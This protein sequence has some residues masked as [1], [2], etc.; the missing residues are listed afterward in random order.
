M[1]INYCNEAIQ[2]MFNRRIFESEIARLVEEGIPVDGIVFEKCTECLSL[3][4]GETGIFR[5]TDEFCFL[6]KKSNDD[7]QLLD[8]MDK[9]HM[10]F[11]PR[12]IGRNSKAAAK[13]PAMRTDTF[14]VKHFAGDAMY[15]INGFI[16]ANGDKLEND[17][18]DVVRSCESDLVRQFFESADKTAAVKLPADATSV[19]KRRHSVKKITI[20][21][22]FRANLKALIT[23]LES[24]NT[25]FLRCIKPNQLKRPD[26]FDAPLVHSQ[27]RYSGVI[28]VVAIR[29]CSFPL[30]QSWSDIHD[31]LMSLKLYKGISEISLSGE[32]SWS[33]SQREEAAKTL[34]KLVFP[35]ESGDYYSG[36]SIVYMK[37]NIYEKISSFLSTKSVICIQQRWRGVVTR[38]RILKVRLAIITLQRLW[39]KRKDR[40][41]R[42]F[43]II[44]C[45]AFFRMCNAKTALVT[46]RRM[47][48]V[49]YLLKRWRTRAR[50]RKRR[51]TTL[52]RLFLLRPSWRLP[53]SRMP[54][55]HKK[56]TTWFRAKLIRLDYLKLRA[57]VT[58]ISAWYRGRTAYRFYRVEIL[59]LRVILRQR[60]ERHGVLKL[61]KYVTLFL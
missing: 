55:A 20:S 30:R 52:I 7:M 50:I 33:I 9:T 60:R 39:W 10:T 2:A 16:N 28:G 53:I 44:I 45:Q 11:N 56:L 47:R 24:T 17:L 42:L 59:Q 4:E 57:A 61:V 19:K 40:A 5:L 32:H 23:E 27:L 13:F 21:A 25:Q 37:Q 48:E 58:R 38:Q 34:F 43:C 31:R 12:Y 1:C 6:G 35:S 51:H 54:P 14:V 49:S 15:C 3:L 36:K 22:K 29:K 41:R 26:I 8:L 46:L 18:A